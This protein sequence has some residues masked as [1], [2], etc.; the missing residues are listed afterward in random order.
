[1]FPNEDLFRVWLETVKDFAIFMVATDGTVASWNVGAERIFGYSEAE[2]LGRSFEC[3]FTPEDRRNGVPAQEIQ[4]ARAEGHGW[5]DRWQVRKDGT[6]F[7]AS[8]LLTPLRTENGALRGFVKVLR[9]NTERKLLEDELRRRARE[10]LEADRRKNEF[11]AM[12]SHEL[13][14][15]LA[16]ILN[17][18]HV[19]RQSESQ[20]DAIVQSSTTI[21]RQVIHLKRLVDDLIDVARVTSGKIQIRKD[22]VRLG[23]ILDRAIEDIEPTLTERQHELTVSIAPEPIWVEA[24]PTRL[25]QILVNLLSN[26]AKYTEPGGHIALLAQVV[27]EEAEIRVSD[28]GIGIDPGLLPNVFNLFTQADDSLDRAQGG[29]GIGLTLTKTLVEMHGGTIV[30]VSDGLGKGSAF[31]VRLPVTTAPESE[32]TIARADKSVKAPHRSRRVLVVDDNIDAAASLSLFLRRAGHVVEVAHEGATALKAAQVFAPDFVLLDIGLPGMNGY[33]VA[34]ALRGLTPAK[35]IAMSGYTQEDD[36][37]GSV[38][39]E[40]LVKPV[41]PDTLLTLLAENE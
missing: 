36:T 3:I 19:L 39:N 34:R 4:E 35:L 7:W 40:Y 31:V 23:E 11:L 30:A 2:I 18:I 37:Q 10:L 17:S 20:D 12:L 5:D 25:E 28:D 15:P 32:P 27:D 29:L 24:D 26:A 41:N 33:D 22:L 9:N 14:N 6:R 16:P 1:M 21:E 13:R 38:F 8:G